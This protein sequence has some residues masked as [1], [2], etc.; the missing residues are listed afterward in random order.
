MSQWLLF[1]DARPLVDR[2]GPRF[3]RE[4]PTCAGVYLMRDAAGQVVYVGK[5]KNLRK[6]LASYRVANPDRMRRRHLRLLR[7]VVG[8][9]LQPCADERSALTR[10]AE[11][12]RTLRPRFNR[13]GTWPA[14]ARY[15]AWR[16]G[17]D[18]LEMSAFLGRAPEAWE[19]HGPLGAGATW[20]RAACLRLLWRV[21]HSADSWSGLPSGWSRGQLGDPA[22]LLFPPGMSPGLVAV[23]LRAVFAGD[24]EPLSAVVQ[25]SLT[26]QTHPV[27]RAMLEEDLETVREFTRRLKPAA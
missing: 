1:P 11:L 24:A 21:A 2:L 27:E 3:F 12:L 23:P 25:T 16:V 6:R 7:T 26:P 8:I 15:L 20:L 19:A 9:E 22:V 18:R 17:T 13:A 10:E 5:A 14:P 4:A